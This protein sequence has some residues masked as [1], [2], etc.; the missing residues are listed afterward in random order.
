[1]EYIK[2][3][4]RRQQVLAAL[5]NLYEGTVERLK[6]Q[7]AAVREALEMGVNQ[8]DLEELRQAILLIVDPSILNEPRALPA[9]NPSE[10]TPAKSV[11]LQIAPLAARLLRSAF[12]G[13]NGR[14]SNPP[15][16]LTE[17][18]QRTYGEEWEQKK[19]SPLRRGTGSKART[20]PAPFMRDDIGAEHS[21]LKTMLS[22]AMDALAYVRKHPEELE[23]APGMIRNL[24]QRVNASDGIHW[25]RMKATLQQWGVS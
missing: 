11:S 6:A 17:L 5:K 13:S 9:E 20:E 7:E 23:T 2:A 1:M 3:L 14:E 8:K 15:A 18:L 16:T 12:G 25:H 21:R 22:R 19:L 24:F 10:T 4:E